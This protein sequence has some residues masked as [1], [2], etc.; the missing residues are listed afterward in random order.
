[1]KFI[2]T[3]AIF[4]LNSIL[5]L[6][7]HRG[8]ACFGQKPTPKQYQK[9]ICRLQ[10][11]RKRNNILVNRDNRGTTSEKYEIKGNKFE[12]NLRTRFWFDF[13]IVERERRDIST[14]QPSISARQ[15]LIG[16]NRG[17]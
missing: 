3:T 5:R 4:A 6:S 15:S 9:N 2:F 12:I 11:T 17:R 8:A 10:G 13:G 16:R 14:L 7:K 1:M